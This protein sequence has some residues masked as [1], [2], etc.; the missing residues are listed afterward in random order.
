MRAHP[1]ATARQGR[2]C[3]QAGRPVTAVPLGGSVEVLPELVEGGYLGVVQH[4]L[5]RHLAVRR[6][7]ERFDD[8]VSEGALQHPEGPIPGAERT[9]SLLEQVRRRRVDTSH[10]G[11]QVHPLEVGR[12]LALHLPDRAEGGGPAQAGEPGGGTHPQRRVTRGQMGAEHRAVDVSS[13]SAD[14]AQRFARG[15]HV[16]SRLGALQNGPGQFDGLRAL[17]AEPCRGQ[18]DGRLH[19][20]ETRVVIRHAHARRP[21]DVPEGAVS[22]AVS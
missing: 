12:G 10:G 4:R 11:Q 22:P 19:R 2:P 16:A 5:P 21:R 9:E 7:L 20:T 18:V 1:A 8:R 14:A 17:S 3:Q 15:A 6:F 13:V